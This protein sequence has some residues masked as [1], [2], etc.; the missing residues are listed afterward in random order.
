MK[1]ITTWAAALA[2]VA[3]ILFEDQLNGYFAGKRLLKGTEKA[4]AVF[5]DSGVFVSET[6]IGKSEFSYDK[7]ALLAETDGYFVFVFSMNHAQMYDKNSLSGGTADMFRKLI[8]GKTGKEIV[9]VR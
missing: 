3:A 4:K 8:T 7:I 2:I 1:D 9:F 6:A 5:D